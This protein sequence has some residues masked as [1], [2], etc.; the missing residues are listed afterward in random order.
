MKA[1]EEVIKELARRGWK[2]TAAESCTGGL[3][4]AGMIDVPGASAVIDRSYITYANEA[5]ESILGVSHDTLERYG[6][7]SE[8]TA[9]EMAFGAAK[10]AG[11]D[12]AVGITGIAGPDGGT[13]E[14]P[15]GLVYTGVYID[16]KVF[17]MRRVHTGTRREIREKSAEEAVL[18]LKDRLFE[19]QRTGS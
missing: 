18:F 4:I 11:A 14:K 9:R 16:G 3:F 7:V 2:L 13:A 6:A 12:A 17:V 1:A 5:K 10:A 15:V 19:E 8:E